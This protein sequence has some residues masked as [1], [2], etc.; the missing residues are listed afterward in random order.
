MREVRHREVSDLLEVLGERGRPL[1]IAAGQ[2]LPEEVQPQRTQGPVPQHF[3]SQTDRQ[4]HTRGLAPLT[5]IQ[6]RTENYILKRNQVAKNIPVCTLKRKMQHYQGPHANQ[7]SLQPELLFS[8]ST[9]HIS[10]VAYCKL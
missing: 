8:H 3:T 1:P 6:Y 7:D 2:A 10:Y 9:S 4:T 5:S